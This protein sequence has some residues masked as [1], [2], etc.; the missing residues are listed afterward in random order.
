MIQNISI[1]NFGSLISAN[2]ATIRGMKWKKGVPE[3][4][5]CVIIEYDT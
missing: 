2:P 4:W 3:R 5:W 1:N